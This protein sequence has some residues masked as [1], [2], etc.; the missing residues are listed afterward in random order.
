MYEIIIQKI[1][2]EVQINGK[3]ILEK[4]REKNID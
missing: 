1:T 3:M 4:L 2:W